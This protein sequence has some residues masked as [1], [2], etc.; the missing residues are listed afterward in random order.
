[1][2]SRIG[3]VTNKMYNKDNIIVQYIAKIF[4][5]CLHIFNILI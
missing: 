2:Y 4:F 3:N 1:M 5:F